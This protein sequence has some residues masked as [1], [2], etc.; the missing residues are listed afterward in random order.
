[1]TEQTSFH[2]RGVLKAGL[3]GAGVLATGVLGSGS[4]AAFVRRDRPVL[5]HGVQSGDVTSHSAVVWTRADRPSRMLV[6][7]SADPSFRRARRM[8]G[9]VLGPRTGGTGKLRIPGLRPGTE[10]HYRVTAEDLDGRATSEPVLG[11]FGTAPLGR[12]DVRLVWSGDV[13]GQGW[14]INPDIGGMTAYAAMAARRPDLFLH[15][16]DTVYADGPMTETVT[17]PDGRVWRNL[18]TPEKTKVAETLD[19]YRG[20]FAYNLLDENVRAFNAAVPS[21]VQWDDHEVTNN[22]YPGEI[23][24]LPEYTEKRVDVLARRGFQAFHEWHPIDARAAVDGRVYR[25]FSHG[26]HAEIFVL[27]MRSYKDANTSDKSEP[28]HVLGQRQANWLVR[29]LAR[30]T[31]TWK[32]VQADLPIGLIVPDGDDIEGVANGLPGAPGGRETELAW[33]LREIARRRVRN[34]VWLT[35]DVHYTAAHHYSPE[36]ASYTDFEPFWEFVSGP[37]HAGAFGPNT[38]DPTFGPKAEFVHAP[39]VANTS[40]MDG[41]QHFGEVNIDGASGDLTVDLRDGAGAS[42]WSKTLHPERR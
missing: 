32:I 35:A 10:L 13:A 41:F 34:V 42:L 8:R 14:G 30:S 12:S 7:V 31:A 3:A 22:W 1:M 20:Q 33:V 21:Y 17:L 29:E 6:E 23:L 38:L 19:E 27:D 11:R 18:M 36:R 2:R 5:T 15:S 37:L 40:P 28:G 26:R 9:P 16:G 25:S 24:D 4:A 39:P